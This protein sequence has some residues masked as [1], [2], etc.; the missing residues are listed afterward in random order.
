MKPESTYQIFYIGPSARGQTP[1]L[2]DRL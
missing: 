2:S 1:N